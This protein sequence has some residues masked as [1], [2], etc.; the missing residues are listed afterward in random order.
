MNWDKAIELLEKG[1]AHLTVV[2]AVLL[3]AEDKVWLS[4]DGQVWGLL[5]NKTTDRLCG[6]RKS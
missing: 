5:D 6:K 4:F 3:D 1:Q 2:T